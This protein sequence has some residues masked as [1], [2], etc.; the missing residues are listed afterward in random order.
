VELK[1]LYKILIIAAALV[2]G[3]DCL[4]AAKLV[5]DG[6][7]LPSHTASLSLPTEAVLRDLKVK[8]GDLVTRGQTLAILYS[9]S[10]EIE[11]QR[12][13]KQLE[14]AEYALA[15]SQKLRVKELVS[16]EETY[17]KQIAR[18]VCKIDARR[19][20]AALLDRTLTAP[21]DGLVLRILKEPGGA[22][23]R[24][25]K[26]MDVVNLKT[27]HVNTFLEGDALEKVNTLTKVHVETPKKEGKKINASIL[28]IDPVVDP[29]SGLFRVRL[30]IQNEDMS[31]PSGIPIKVIF[32]L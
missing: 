3:S 32:E 11:N 13:E 14:L 19:T 6:I 23:S 30:L 31:I 16:V 4:N 12:A 7:I 1:N 29:G 28:M 26:I 25:D 9:T 22:V 10:E 2:G 17:Q 20:A 15:T 24:A 27:L 18:D 5:T 21:F 8:E